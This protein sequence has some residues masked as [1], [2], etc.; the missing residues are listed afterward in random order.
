MADGDGALEHLLRELAHAPDVEPEPHALLHYRVLG[1]LGE[2]GMGTVYKAEDTKLGRTIAIKRVAA[3]IG[4]DPQARLRLVREARAASALSHPNIV[5]VHA[6]E[7]VDGVTFIVMEYVA[8]ET[9]AELIARAQIPTPRALAIAADIADALDHA[10]RA[11]VVHRDIKPANIVVAEDGRVKVLDFG[12]AKPE[13]SPASGDESTAMPSLTATGAV[14]GT[15]PYM[16]P[17]QMRGEELD[18]R[19][20]IFA[21]GC[22][23]YEMLT[24]RRAFPARDIASLVDQITRGARTPPSALRA[25]V[26]P[27]IDAIAMRALA[28]D[29]ADRFATA[30][31]LAAALRAARG[32]STDTFAQTAAASVASVAPAAP[33]RSRRWVLAAIGALVVA[34][35]GVVVV[36]VSRSK[37]APP[38]VV[39]DLPIPASSSAEAAAAYR[40][41]LQATRD[42]N[43]RAVV[44]SFQ[45]A[46][47]LDK[48]MAMAFFRYGDAAWSSNSAAAGR[49]ALERAFALRSTL[50]AHD[51]LL[52]DTY[53]PLIH[54]APPDLAEYQR[55]TAAFARAYPDDAD[56]ANWECWGAGANADYAAAEQ[57]ARRGLE[58]DPKSGF[59][60]ACL[61]QALGDRGRFD[62]ARA[63]QDACIAACPT[64]TVC[65]HDAMSEQAWRGDCAAYDATTMKLAAV[66]LAGNAVR[67][68]SLARSNAAPDIVRSAIP[69]D[70]PQ[71][72]LAYDIWAGDFAAVLARAPQIEGEIAADRDV[73]AA[74]RRAHLY[75]VALREA[76]RGDDAA[77]V[78]RAFVARRQV[79]AKEGAF[80]G[81]LRDDSAYVLALAHVGGTVSDA[82][83]RQTRD[84]WLADWRQIS[85]GPQTTTQAW[86][87][88]F[89]GTATTRDDAASALAAM[90]SELRFARS[91]RFLAAMGHMYVLL[92]RWNDAR[93]LLEQAARG[94]DVLEDAPT[95]VAAHAELAQTYEAMHEPARACTERRWIVDR[96][97][98][99]KPGS[100]T[101]EAAARELGRLGCR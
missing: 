42:G 49:A 9:L 45:R 80:G 46:S 25:G 8:G 61:E 20:D 17:E 56:A 70:D 91:T 24:G 71:Q 99:A 73:D 59:L 98:A 16:S 13:S 14:A 12:L 23:L 67:V 69:P 6:I 10:H 88:L 58:L 29:R 90:P 34:A 39:T 21:L 79:L 43:L 82:E 64:N 33:R 1:R 4:N 26:P 97:G 75:A 52:V 28:T 86:A 94:C 19:T 83:L 95:I 3:R 74:S 62:E 31:E 38:V 35:G 72:R 51:Q 55:L 18:G 66:S 54:R 7:E 37:P 60:W 36:T 32:K 101:A 47:E 77:R 81:T 27:A 100:I 92:G 53:V 11:G 48:T 68:S 40:A 57:I 65:L 30:G 50:D 15:G 76:G 89:A 78:A 96:W 84:A 85:T 87:A 63:A 5:T 2:G 93:P 41:G 22:V 44:E